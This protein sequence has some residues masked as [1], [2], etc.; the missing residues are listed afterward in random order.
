MKKWI[1][2]IGWV[3]AILTFCK[4]V[5]DLKDKEAVKPVE[6]VQKKILSVIN[7]SVYKLGVKYKSGWLTYHE[8]IRRNNKE[9]PDRERV[10]DQ[11][12]FSRFILVYL[13]SDKPP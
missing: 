12:V 3:I 4:S 11:E 10:H 7:S 5:D 8:N 2:V 6:V 1:L 13:F 9:G